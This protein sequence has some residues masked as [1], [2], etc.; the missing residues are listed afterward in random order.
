MLFVE[1]KGLFN[2][3]I[4]SR[5]RS[6]ASPTL[7]LRVSSELLSGLS[8]A[9]RSR[10]RECALSACSPRLGECFL[11]AESKTRER[12][13]ISVVGVRCRR[14]RHQ[15][16]H[17]GITRVAFS[18]FPAL[19]LGPQPDPLRL[20]ARRAHSALRC[21]A[22][23]ESRKGVTSCG[24]PPRNPSLAIIGG[25][26]KRSR[27]SSL[28]AHF[29]S[30]LFQPR[31]P[32]CSHHSTGKVHGSLAR[33]G[34]VRGQTPKVAKQDKKKLPKVSCFLFPFEV[35]SSPE[36]ESP[37]ARSPSVLLSS[38]P[39]QKKTQIKQTTGP[40]HEAHQVQPPLR[41]RRRRHGQ[42]EEPELAVEEGRGERERRDFEGKER[43]ERENEFFFF[44]FSF[45]FGFF[46][47]PLFLCV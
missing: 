39:P 3:T 20:V 42:E 29:L 11:D 30:F 31:L 10:P 28:F 26:K 21:R 16:Q 24:E 41:Q 14:R 22:R 47:V 27:F 33:A 8:R 12:R 18:P 4:A 38:S 9:A 34:K 45:F 5:R 35:S 7:S 6:S 44:C 17:G 19:S 37:E 13:S 25:S 40:R 46:F 32:P 43:R 15:Q 1:S 2:Q 36:H 23:N